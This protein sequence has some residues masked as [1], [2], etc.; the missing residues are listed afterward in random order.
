[1]AGASLDVI[2]FA[3]VMVMSSCNDDRLRCQNELADGNSHLLRRHKS[4]MI[5]L[6]VIVRRC[7]TANVA[8]YLRIAAALETAPFINAASR[9]AAY[10][11]PVEARRRAAGDT[12][13]RKY[14]QAIIGASSRQNTR[15]LKG[16]ATG[17]NLS[18]AIAD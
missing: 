8:Q 4:G 15:G 13:T 9:D 1:M 3:A 5:R 16:E 11:E 17:A 14:H 10:R 2:F 12:M 7:F 6:L 18:G